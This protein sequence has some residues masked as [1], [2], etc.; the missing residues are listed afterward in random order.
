MATILRR[1]DESHICHSILHSLEKDSCS[2]IF[3]RCLI[4]LFPHVQFLFFAGA[5]LTYSYATLRNI[6]RDNKDHKFIKP[7]LVVTQ[8]LPDDTNPFRGTHLKK[9]VN[10]TN[11]LD[12]LKLNQSHL[13]GDEGGLEFNPEG[14]GKADQDGDGKSDLKMMQRLEQVDDEFDADIIEFDDEF[15]GEGLDSELVFSIVLNRTEK[16]VT[17]CFRGS[18]SLKDWV[19]DLSGT[20]RKPA[21]IKEFADDTGT[22]THSGFSGKPY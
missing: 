12:F 5:A 9:T 20:K 3:S 16:R 6:V 4:Y 7:E 18:V 1:L 17:V 14:D 13:V 19:V 11:I 15:V 22:E 21:I 2:L 8:H 10:A